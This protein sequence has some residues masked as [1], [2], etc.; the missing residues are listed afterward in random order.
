MRKSCAGLTRASIPP[1]HFSKQ[2][3]CRIKSGNDDLAD[4]FP[5][6]EVWLDEELGLRGLRSPAAD[7]AR[8]L[9]DEVLRRLG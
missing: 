5:G 4:L 6:S 3:D 7:E 1:K 8:A 9:G 2:M